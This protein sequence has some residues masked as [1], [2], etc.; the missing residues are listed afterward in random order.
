MSMTGGSEMADGSGMAGVFHQFA[1]GVGQRS[2]GSKRT[3]P[4]RHRLVRSQDDWDPE[5][6]LNRAFDGN[7]QMDQ[8]ERIED[9]AFAEKN[10]FA[11]A[12]RLPADGHER[13]EIVERLKKNSDNT[14]SVNRHGRF[15]HR[16]PGKHGFLADIP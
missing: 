13:I 15:S 11:R 9:S 1:N 14:I 3:L 4:A 8:S 10:H 7:H 2:D 5:D 6:V 12:I 16:F